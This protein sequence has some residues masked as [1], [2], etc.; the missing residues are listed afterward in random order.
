VTQRRWIVRRLDGLLVPGFTK[1]FPAGGADGGIGRTSWFGIPIGRFRVE[2][3]PS[4]VTRL[5]YLRWP[6][7]DEFS[8]TPDGSVDPIGSAGFIR[9]PGGRRMRFCRFALCAEE[10]MS[11][12]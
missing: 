11:V 8:A 9:L 6:V 12:V 10:I 4:G 5:H 1:Q 7:V 3:G 2:V